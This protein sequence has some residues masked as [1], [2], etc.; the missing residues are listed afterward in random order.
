VISAIKK[1]SVPAKP[2]L[3]M[4]LAPFLLVEVELAEVAVDE[5]L[6]QE[7]LDGIVKLFDRVKSAHWMEKENSVGRSYGKDREAA[8]KRTW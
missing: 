1:P 2:D 4:P 3:E 6:E 7:T 8:R 5:E